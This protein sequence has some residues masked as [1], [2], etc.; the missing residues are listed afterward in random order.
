MV[1]NSTMA[2]ALNGMQAFVPMLVLESPT[3]SAFMAILLLADLTPAPENPAN[4][5]VEISHPWDLFS[6][7]SFHGGSWRCG[8][9]V[10]SIGT[11]TYVMGKVSPNTGTAA[12]VGAAK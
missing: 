3:A 8:Y 10:D 1:S 12:V 4:A 5:V 2:T 9:T 6:Y 11:A 7:N